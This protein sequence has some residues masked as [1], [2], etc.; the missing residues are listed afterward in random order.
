MLRRGATPRWTTSAARLLGVLALV[1][2]G[3]ATTGSGEPA[4]TADCT[5]QV[6]REGVVYSGYG[7]SEHPA[8]KRGT[9]DRAGCHDLGR[10]AQGSVFTDDPAQVGVWTFRG[11]AI[12]K[13]LGVRGAGG[14]FEVFVAESLS[15]EEAERILRRLDRDGR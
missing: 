10:D 6:R 15:R 4:S 3:C 5:S 14:S 8:T 13:V 9:A 7:H 2:G 11:Y 12:E 1:T